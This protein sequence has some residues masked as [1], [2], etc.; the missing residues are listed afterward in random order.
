MLFEVVCQFACFF[1][2]NFFR[3]FSRIFNVC[4]FSVICI[5]KT[6][7]TGIENQLFL[8]TFWH[9]ASNGSKLKSIVNKMYFPFLGMHPTNDH[10]TLHRWL[11][12]FLSISLIVHS[13]Y[14]S[15]VGAVVTAGHLWRHPGRFDGE[16]VCLRFRKSLVCHSTYLRDVKSVN[17]FFQIGS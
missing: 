3:F 9:L 4:V 17:L 6:L 10:Y 5:S 12:T 13:R 15:G 1:K 8:G 7:R 11:C 2:R 16:S 14:E